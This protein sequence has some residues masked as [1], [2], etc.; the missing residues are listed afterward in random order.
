MTLETG[1]VIDEVEA[2]RTELVGLCARLVGAPSVNP[3]GDTRAVFEVARSWLTAHDIA[4]SVHIAEPTKPNLVARINGAGPGRH[5]VFNGHLDTM[6]VGDEA[7]WTVPPFE[8]THRDDRL[9]G[10]GMGNMKGAVAGLCVAASILHRHRSEWAGEVTLTLVSDEVYFGGDG[11][12]HL[13][14]ALPWLVADGVISGEG[15]GWMSLA[16]AEKGVI[17]L[18]V[19]ATGPSGHASSAATGTTAVARLAQG[20]VALDQLNDW[21]SPVL[22]ELSGFLADPA[23]PG[24]RVA[25]NVG[26]LEGGESRSRLATTA[27]ARADVRLP[28]GIPLDAL[29]ARLHEILDAIEGISWSLE[30]AWPANWSAPDD[31][32]VSA[33]IG[34]ATTVLGRPVELTVRHPASDLVRWRQL[35]T[36]GCAF[37]PQPTLSAGIDDYAREDDVVDCAK[38]YVLAA[39]A[40]LEP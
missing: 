16:P 11:T 7:S 19:E 18:D 36:P 29:E 20:V 33:V 22:D 37:G 35:G 14:E 8:L 12:A 38:V 17:W 39:L 25:L 28:P 30:R 4:T 24:R 31:P 40:F 13:L 6:E 32:L 21:V 1:A 2:L 5:L 10:L 9:Y 34:A 15:S 27:R 26:Q 23:H 3:P